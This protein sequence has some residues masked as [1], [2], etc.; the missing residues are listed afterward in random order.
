MSYQSVKTLSHNSNEKVLTK[1]VRY[2]QTTFWLPASIQRLGSSFS[3]CTNCS[4]SLRFSPMK[5]IMTCICYPEKS[6]NR[7]ELCCIIVK[8]P[9]YFLFP[10]SR[11]HQSR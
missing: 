1:P 9:R 7:H 10:D 4:I 2:F 11:Q 6:E 5:R 3:F 8:P